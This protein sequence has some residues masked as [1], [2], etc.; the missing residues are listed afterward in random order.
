[1]KY[2]AKLDDNYATTRTLSH[3]STKVQNSTLGTRNSKKLNNSYN[4]K[5]VCYSIM[6]VC[7]SGCVNKFSCKKIHLFLIKAYY[8][9]LFILL[10]RDIVL[11]VKTQEVTV[12]IFFLLP[13]CKCKSFCGTE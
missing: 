3:I 5:H 13:L 7:V 9:K 10:T 12:D 4:H 8:D 1:M 6:H 11:L 2:G